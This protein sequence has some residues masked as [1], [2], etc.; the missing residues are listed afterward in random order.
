MPRGVG[1]LL[2]QRCALDAAEAGAARDAPPLAQE[3]LLRVAGYLGGVPAGHA[4]PADGQPRA[5]AKAPQPLQECR[6][7]LL[8]PG[9]PC[10]E[11]EGGAG[12]YIAW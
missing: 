11:R 7:L 4:V 8:L 6:M 9:Q 5:P 2:P 1:H 3:V 10:I 12:F